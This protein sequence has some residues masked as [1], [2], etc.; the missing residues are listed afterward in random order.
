VRIRFLRTESFRLTALYAA[1]FAISVVILGV[2]L[3][4]ITTGALRDQILVFPPPTSPPSADGYATRACM[5]ARSHQPADGRYRPVPVSICWRDGK[6][7]DGNLAAMP[8]APARVRSPPQ[9]AQP[10]GAWDWAPRAGPLCFPGDTAQLRGV[11]AI[12]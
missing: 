8:H 7:L 3:L 4:V 9:R 12:S 2:F 11:Q 10:P 6:V 5:S 1:I